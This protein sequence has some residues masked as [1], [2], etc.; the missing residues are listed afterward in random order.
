[1]YKRQ[2]LNNVASGDTISKIIFFELEDGRWKMEDENFT[3]NLVLLTSSFYYASAN[4]FCPAS[5]ASSMVPL[6]LK[7]ASGK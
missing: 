7:A 1:M 6:R 5:I 4:I 3:S 2:P